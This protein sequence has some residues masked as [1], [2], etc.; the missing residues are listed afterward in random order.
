MAD[1]IRLGKELNFDSEVLLATSH[2]RRSIDTL[3]LL[4]PEKANWDCK[5]F[6][7]LLTDAYEI[8]DVSHVEGLIP[9]E[10]GTNAVEIP[11]ARDTLSKLKAIS[12]RWAIV[13]S[14]TKAL[15]NGV[16]YP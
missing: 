15:M 12:A 6:L 1:D 13:T 2:G 3:K 9:I 11:G 4:A 8:I 10:L 14:G 7:L 5:F 16:G